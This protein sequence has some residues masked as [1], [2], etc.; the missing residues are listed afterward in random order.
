M[1]VLVTALCNQPDA[2]A[3]ALGDPVT[4]FVVVMGEHLV[5][6]MVI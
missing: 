3:L 1:P 2:S 4:L 6:M 5:V